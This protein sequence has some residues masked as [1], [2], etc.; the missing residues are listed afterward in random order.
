MCRLA[1]LL[2]E[3]RD[4]GSGSDQ[5]LMA[6]RGP[7]TR[8][9][10][11]GALSPSRLA[12]WAGL[13]G[14][15]LAALLLIWWQAWKPAPETGPVAIAILTFDA[16]GG[17]A[18]AAGLADDLTAAL[19]A[20]LGRNPNVLVSDRQSTAE[21]ENR[22]LSAQGIGRGLGVRYLVEGGVRSAGGRVTLNVRLID[23]STGGIRWTQ[24][25]DRPLADLL[26][27]REEVAD[28]LAETIIRPSE[29]AR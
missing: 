2:G 10:P 12:G 6:G 23:V 26:S 11:P 8:P 25:H 20:E 15:V 21:Y 3:S 5:R 14:F 4:R 22:A 9:L 29:S 7:A 1:R 18:P 17:D 24:R 16:P 28:Q 27:L 13:V 19:R